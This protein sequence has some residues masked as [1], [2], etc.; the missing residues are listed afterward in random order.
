MNDKFDKVRAPIFFFLKLLFLEISSV[1]NAFY[2]PT[3]LFG[4]FCAN[5]APSTGHEWVTGQM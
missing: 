4:S 5:G 1:V 3:K 2:F